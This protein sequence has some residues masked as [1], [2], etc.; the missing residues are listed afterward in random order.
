MDFES[1]E[2]KYNEVIPFRT[3]DGKG[4]AKIATVRMLKMAA[5][6][7]NRVPPVEASRTAKDG[8]HGVFVPTKRTGAVVLAA[9]VATAHNGRAGFQRSTQVVVL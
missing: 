2:V 9:T 3:Y 8:E 1:N 7:G 4:E 5:L 6:K